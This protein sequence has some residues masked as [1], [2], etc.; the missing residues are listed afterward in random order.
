MVPL[1]VYRHPQMTPTTMQVYLALASRSYD[2]KVPRGAPWVMRETGLGRSSVYS[3]L[4]TLKEVGAMV[5]DA[6]GMFL[7]TDDPHRQESTSVDSE[8][9][10]STSVDSKSTSVDSKSTTVDSK[11]TSVDSRC[12]YLEEGLLEEDLLENPSAAA[13]PEKVDPVDAMAQRLTVLAFE[14]TPAPSPR[15]GFLAV[16]TIIKRL[17]TAGHAP[18]A[19]ADVIEAGDIV[20]TLAGLELKL[21]QLH[22][23][24]TNGSRSSWLD[25]PGKAPLAERIAAS[26][27]A[28]PQREVGR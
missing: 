1:W 9:E 3:A 19:V 14:Q 6:D 25:R 12:S 17:L 22:R 10:E 24:A 15:G 26:L 20:W 28:E 18:Q 7:P 11:S 21:T 27:G 4:A 8:P 5:E 13:P 2:R 16:R 23:P